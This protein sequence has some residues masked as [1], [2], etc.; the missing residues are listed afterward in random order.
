[1]SVELDKEY[2]PEL[3]D[4]NSE[5]YKKLEESINKVVSSLITPL[6]I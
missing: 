3:G 5:Q 1:M 4:K 6:P 2:E